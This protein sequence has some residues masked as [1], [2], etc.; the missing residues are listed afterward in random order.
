M[1]GRDEETSG[2]A[3]GYAPAVRGCFCFGSLLYGTMWAI[4][5]MDL[6]FF[7]SVY[8]LDFIRGVSGIGLRVIAFGTSC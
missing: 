1:S 4:S 3:N 6:A 2:Y 7:Y 5:C 8:D